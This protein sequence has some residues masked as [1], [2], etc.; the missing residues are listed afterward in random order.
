MLYIKMY[1]TEKGS[2]IAMCDERLLGKKYTDRKSGARLDL[3]RYS[4]FYKGDLVDTEDAKG[5]IMR[6][7]IYSANIVGKESVSLIV[8]LGLAG[9]DDVK[10]VDSIPSLQIYRVL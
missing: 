10:T 2:I 1:D 9:E 6:E 4:D 8:K 3:D 7:N 5:R